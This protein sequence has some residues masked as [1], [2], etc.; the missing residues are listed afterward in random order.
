MIGS[1]EIIF[2]TTKNGRQP[3]VTWLRR[4]DAKS[5]T[6]IN[7]R[8]ARIRGGNFGDCKQIKG[9]LGLWEFRINYG[10]GFRIYFGKKG[11]KVIVLLVGGEKGSQKRDIMRAR[12]YWCECEKLVYE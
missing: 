6:V 3:F 7:A 4:L 11:A 10:P 9:V 12:F 1:V 2:Y 8:I 5:K